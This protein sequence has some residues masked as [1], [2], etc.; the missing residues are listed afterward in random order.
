MLSLNVHGG[1]LVANYPFDDSDELPR[2][3]F[4]KKRAA[5][6]YSDD[7]DV[8]QHVASIYAQ[9]HPTMHLG[10]GCQNDEIGKA[11]NLQKTLQVIL[12]LYF[13]NILPFHY[14]VWN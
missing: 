6:S 12:I 2:G 5:P 1:A 10:R 7:T 4:G 8:F 3:S 9:A 11:E 13:E 14:I